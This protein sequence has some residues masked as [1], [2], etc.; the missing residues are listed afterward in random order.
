MVVM[1]S[2]VV[3]ISKLRYIFS[4]ITERWIMDPSRLKRFGAQQVLL[5]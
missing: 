3:N 1:K 4:C 5:D 2:Q